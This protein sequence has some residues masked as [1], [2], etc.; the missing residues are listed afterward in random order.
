MVINYAIR[1]EKYMKVVKGGSTNEWLQDCFDGNI[2]LALNWIE[3]MRKLGVKLPKLHWLP[4][5]PG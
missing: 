3:A 1:V 2:L 5:K 4:G